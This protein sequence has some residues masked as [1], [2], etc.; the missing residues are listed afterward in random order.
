MANHKSAIRQWRKNL[1]R[2]T[3]NRRN[4][5]I[6]RSQIKNIRTAIQTNDKETAEK[7]LPETISHIDRAVK[8][9][10]IHLNTGNRYK[11]RLCRQVSSITVAAP[12]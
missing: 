3:I 1:R 7:L 6:L 2:N 4:K 8:K 9:G 12:K 5:S 10:A 11:S